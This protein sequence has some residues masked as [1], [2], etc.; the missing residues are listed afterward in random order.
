M[1]QGPGRGHVRDEG[2]VPGRGR[3]RRVAGRDRAAGSS[4]PDP[5]R[6]RAAER[7]RGPGAGG[8]DRIG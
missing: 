2:A 3:R 5:D 7:R 4:H 1:G 8:R 6:L